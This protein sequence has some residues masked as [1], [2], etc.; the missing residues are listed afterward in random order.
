MPFNGVDV[1]TA[2]ELSWLGA[3]GKPEVAI[4]EIE[5]PCDSPNIVESKSLKLYFN[6]LNQSKL[7]NADAVTSLI[8]A[9]MSSV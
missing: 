6:S 8:A 4:A 9:D 2:Y 5:I 7:E 1:W 3:N